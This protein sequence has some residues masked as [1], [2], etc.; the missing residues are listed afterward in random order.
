MT[1]R[2]KS[3]REGKQKTH[4]DR[5]EINEHEQHEI[6]DTVQWE[7]EDEKVVWNRL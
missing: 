1:V 2:S 7:E 6:H 5:P 4:E 3:K